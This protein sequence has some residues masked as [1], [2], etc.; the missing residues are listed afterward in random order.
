MPIK[1]LQRNRPGLSRAGIVR[2]GY[3]MRKCKGCGN[4]PAADKCPK[5]GKKDFKMRKQ[6]ENLVP[7]EFPTPADHFV[8]TDAPGVAEAL[9]DTKPTELRI[10]FPFNEIDMVFPAFYQ[11]WVSGGLVCRGD[12]EHILYTI[13]PQ[14]GKTII[15]DG[16]AVL[17]FEAKDWRCEIGEVLPCSG[18]DGNLYKKCAECKPNAM[19]IVLLRDVPRLAY[20]QIATTSIHNIV[21]L[22]EQLTYIKENVGK[23]QGV[24]FILKLAER[25]ISA[26]VGDNGKRQRVKKHLLSLEV[27]PEYYQRIVQM[28]HQL[29]APERRLL[30]EPESSPVIE[31]EPSKPAPEISTIEPPVWM[32]PNGGDDSEFITTDWDAFCARVMENIPYYAD[33]VSIASTME[34]LN[35]LNYDPENEDFIFAQLARHAQK[36]ADLDIAHQEADAILEQPALVEQENGGAAYSEN[37]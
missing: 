34:N 6:G 24:P 35:C 18:K 23:L 19:L 37:S 14:S 13:N 9:G 4:V 3:K 22:T 12:G 25:E 20:Y 29:A 17:D 31:V 15:R 30:A 27:D 1:D 32:A 36:Q 33:D 16:Q 2:L 28:Q 21:N 10:W 5:C 11:Y 26:P 7:I 8:L